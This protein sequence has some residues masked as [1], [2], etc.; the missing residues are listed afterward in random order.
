MKKTNFLTSYKFAHR[1][2]HNNIIPEN[3]FK[4]FINAI[5]NGYAIELDIRVTK[6]NKWV[7][8]HDKSLK[9]MAK[10]DINL[11]D[12]DYD[13]LKH[14]LLG[15]S[16]ETIPL[17]ENVLNL[18]NG[19]TPLLIEIKPIKNKKKHLKT[20]V[21]LLDSYKGDFAI[22]SF[23]PFIINWFKKNRPNYIRGQISSF[24]EDNKLPN[25]LKYFYKS[26]FFN[27][28]TKPEF[29]SYNIENIPN[30][31]INKA[32]SKGII[33]FGYTARSIEEYQKAL[34]YLDNV[35]FENFKF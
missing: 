32:R 20:L 10:E 26:M 8:F 25:F 21:N 6:D 1:G 35:V 19:K 24:F 30:K 34:K 7:V 14:H 23:S 17:F 5:E 18:V 15:N 2:L 13:D 16:L 29:I 28:F 11:S 9:R 33:L 3:S 4:S 31:Y 27:R 12:L 22:F